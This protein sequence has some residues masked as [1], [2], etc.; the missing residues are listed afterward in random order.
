MAVT[1][2]TF[3]NHSPGLEAQAIPSST[4]VPDN[5]I[6][7]N[8]IT[9]TQAALSFS[10]DGQTINLSDTGTFDLS[11]LGGK[12]PKTVADLSAASIPNSISSFTIGSGGVNFFTESFSPGLTFTQIGDLMNKGPA[13]VALLAGN[14]AYY[15]AA[16]ATG[17]N[18]DSVYLYGGNDTYYVNHALLTKVDLF[19]GGD[20]V[21]TAVFN[22]KAANFTIATASVWNYVT[23]KSDLPGFSVTDKTKTINTLYVN[24]VER[25]QF[26]DFTVALDTGAKQTAGSGYMLYKAAFNRTPDAGG[27][28]YWISNMDSGMSYNDVAKN[29]VTSTEFKMAFGGSNP[30]VNTLVTKLYNNVLNR[31][32]DAGG[33]AFWQDKLNTGWSTADV[34]GFFSTS[35]ENVTNVTP[36]IA[37]GIS[38]TQFVG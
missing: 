25:L 34:L 20:G 4:P 7:V 1:I 5:Q 33:L 19:F 29:F 30:S 6:N 18:N 2:R 36:L 17:S 26:T 28:G 27:L 31:T 10:L 9:S 35:A 14:D 12:T 22:Q 13:M 3:G 32:P 23:Q 24:Q 16:D 11:A 8:S 21:D 38:Y 15:A 37:N